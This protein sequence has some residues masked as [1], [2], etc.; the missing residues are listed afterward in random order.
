MLGEVGNCSVKSVG[1]ER[2]AGSAFAA[3]RGRVAQK[4]EDRSSCAL[5][6]KPHTATSGPR[7]A[8]TVA[9]FQRSNALQANL[10]EGPRAPN[11]TCRDMRAQPAVT[12]LVDT[13]QD[14]NK[15]A[16]RSLFIHAARLDARN[17]RGDTALRF[18]IRENRAGLVSLLLD[19]GLDPDL[20]EKDRPGRTPIELAFE[21][22]R[23]SIARQLLEW[24]AH[25]LGM[26]GLPLTFCC[27]AWGQ[28][29]FIQHL[30]RHGEDVDATDGS[31]GTLL[32]AAAANDDLKAIAV[33]IQ[34]G[35]NLLA[36]THSGVN[37]A[38][39]AAANGRL[40]ALQLFIRDLHVPLDATT[41]SGLS[42]VLIAAARG[43]VRVL[44]YLVAQGADIHAITHNGQ[45]IIMLAA[46]N[47][48][49][50]VLGYVIEKLAVPASSATDDSGLTAVHL[51]AAGGH[52]NVVE[53][54]VTQRAMGQARTDDGESVAIIAARNGQ[55]EVLE[56]L[57][58][59]EAETDSRLAAMSPKDFAAL[60]Q[61]M[62]D[63]RDAIVGDA[64]RP[65]THTQ[66]QRLFDAMLSEIEARRPVTAGRFNAWLARA[67]QGLWSTAS[68]TTRFLK[69]LEVLVVSLRA[70]PAHDSG[71]G[72]GQRLDDTA[73]AT[74]VT[75]ELVRYCSTLRTHGARP[76]I[77]WSSAAE[78]RSHLEDHMKAVFTTRTFLW[79]LKAGNV[80][81]RMGLKDVL[82]AET[83]GDRWQL[84]RTSGHKTLIAEYRQA[85]LAALVTE[86]MQ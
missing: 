11:R 62:P 24:K 80:G 46:A 64:T 39:A 8:A 77:E 22:G 73:C 6:T 67:R 55:L 34:N 45:D 38:M 56:F 59:G 33:L 18:A 84:H 51:A 70:L 63:P 16:V 36:T 2:T 75:T 54:L 74:L 50:A 21:L 42:A 23:V 85:R 19:A 61:S 57:K 9:P 3:T 60:V 69:A 12:T 37:A 53:Y 5:S 47:G 49:L 25:A 83:R 72:R 31:G 68:G 32:I 71:T 26:H 1:A 48:R 82:R 76:G 44:K 43:H 28:P 27:A 15:A 17:S 79:I 41:A 78:F 20:N 14:L 13:P 29:E 52:L 35:A 81:D 58:G 40:S 66:E 86:A 7:M 30:L 65:S 10:R 4:D